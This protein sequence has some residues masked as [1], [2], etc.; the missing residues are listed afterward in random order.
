[1][2]RKRILIVLLVFDLLILTVLGV[3]VKRNVETHVNEDTDLKAAWRYTGEIHYQSLE[4]DIEFSFHPQSRYLSHIECIL[5]NLPENVDGILNVEI[6][7]GEDTSGKRVAETAVPLAEIAAGEWQKMVFD[8]WLSTS[9]NY[10]MRFHVAGADMIPYLV[11]A[12]KEIVIAEYEENLTEGEGGYPAVSYCY[13]RR[14]SLTAV[15]TV[16]LLLLCINA[17]II[18]KRVNTE[19]KKYLRK[20]GG[21]SAWELVC[22]LSLSAL[23]IFVHVYRLKEVPV[24]MNIDEIGMGY[25][26]WALSHFG[27]DRWGVSFPV[28]LQNHGNGQ[29]VLYCLLCMPFIRL[30]GITEIAMRIPAVLASL[31]TMIIGGRLI[32][33]Q[34]RDRRVLFLYALLM[35][36]TPY[37]IYS[38]RIGLD[39]NLFLM[40]STLFLYFFEKAR[41][42]Q[43]TGQWIAAGIAGGVTLYSYALSWIVLPVFLVLTF[44][45]MLWTKQLRP[46][47]L[48]AMGIPL[49]LLALPLLLFNAVNMFEWDSIHLGG[50]TIPRIPSYR[51]GM[52]L[53]S[54]E[55]YTVLDKVV[56]MFRALFAD[57]GVEYP[58]VMPLY[59]IAIPFFCIGLWRYYTAFVRAIKKRRYTFACTGLFWLAAQCVMGL[60]IDVPTTY[61]LNGIFL[62]IL[63]LVTEGIRY[64]FENKWEGK[65][66]ILFASAGIYFLCFISFGNRY[67]EME[68]AE[69]YTFA[70]DSLEEVNDEVLAEVTRKAPQTPVYIYTNDNWCSYIYYLAANGITPEEFAEGGASRL[71]WKNV[72][73]DFPHDGIDQSAVYV[74]M[75]GLE[76]KVDELYDLGMRVKKLEHYYIV[77]QN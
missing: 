68:N 37:F 77:W 63:F 55:N 65:K 26:A 51:S 15:L 18:C 21:I 32:W 73:F 17:F 29:S 72:F 31:V 56:A 76:D 75:E 36:I 39:C 9:E 53:Q 27:V 19:Q 47:N 62:M 12:D 2:E 61:R 13:G 35:T 42:G 33:S 59:W 70:Y 67:L 46:R 16:L 25:D 3:W 45:W 20:C 60:C 64:A 40:M 49:F 30:L 23:F 38:G 11:Y 71:S 48:L 58:P 44:G 4:Q 74:I 34:Y 43:R 14:I 69:R 66:P 5:I 10:L 7:A 50:I 22:W 1:M 54:N 41:C 6:Y 52:L 28:Y 57:S 8:V 24:G